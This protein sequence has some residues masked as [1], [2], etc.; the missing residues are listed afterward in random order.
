M[1]PHLGMRL[2]APVLPRLLADV[3]A[4]VNLSARAMLIKKTRTHTHAIRNLCPSVEPDSRNLYQWVPV[5]RK[6]FVRFLPATG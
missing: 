5:L 1:S 2:C 3:F 6:A 4:L